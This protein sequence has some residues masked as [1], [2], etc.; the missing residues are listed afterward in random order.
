MKKRN[1]KRIA[2]LENL[3]TLA[4]KET[5]RQYGA[6]FSQ[7]TQ[8]ANEALYL[9]AMLANIFLFDYIANAVLLSENFRQDFL[10]AQFN[11]IEESYRDHIQAEDSLKTVEDRFNTYAEFP[12]HHE[13]N[14]FNYFVT[15][16]T[17]NLN[18]SQAYQLVEHEYEDALNP[19]QTQLKQMRDYQDQLFQVI[20]TALPLVANKGQKA[21]KAWNQAAAPEQQVEL[22]QTTLLARLANL[23]KR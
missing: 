19:D 6:V 9:E 7:D 20:Q 5:V 10:E 4:T 16:L 17:K 11:P 22:P 2:Q 1:E 13:N 14:W 3:L 15:Y 23:F 12:M 8:K 21:E 18:G